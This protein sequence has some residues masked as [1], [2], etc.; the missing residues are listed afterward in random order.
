[1]GRL[2]LPCLPVV[3]SPADLRRTNH[4]NI[5]VRG[6]KEE[7]TIT[8]PIDMTVLNEPDLPPRDGRYRPACRR[9]SQS[10]PPRFLDGLHK[11][12]PNS[13]LGRRARGCSGS[14]PASQMAMTLHSLMSRRAYFSDDVEAERAK[15][16]VGLT[17]T[18]PAAE[19]ARSDGCASY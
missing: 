15:D 11:Q 17:G 1:M 13:T 6:Y 5:H 16:S 7:G 10:C 4:D 12:V 19:V 9:R 18:I 3:H 8:T 2:R 14:S